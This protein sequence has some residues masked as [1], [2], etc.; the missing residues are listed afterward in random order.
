MRNAPQL[1]AST[2][3]EYDAEKSQ[4]RKG[5]CIW[6]TGYGLPHTTYCKRK[7]TH[8]PH[9]KEHWRD[10]LIQKYGGRYA[11]FVGGKDGKVVRALFL[12]DH[13]LDGAG[14]TRLASGIRMGG[15]ARTLSGRVLGK[16]LV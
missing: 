14:A 1:T 13:V 7:A 10:L 6:Q 9:C 4:M 16:R 15:S 2:A 5:L 12:S 8:G 3:R 11:V